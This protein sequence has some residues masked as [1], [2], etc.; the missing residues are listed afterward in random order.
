MNLQQFL[1]ELELGYLTPIFCMR[2]SCN[3]CEKLIPKAVASSFNHSGMLRVF[4]TALELLRYLYA[5]IS[6]SMIAQNTFGPT[7]T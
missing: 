4:Y 2:A 3:T 7:T 5:S 1:F 6:N